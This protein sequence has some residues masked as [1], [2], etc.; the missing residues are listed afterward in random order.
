ML[1]RF[2]TAY[3]AWQERSRER[4]LH[5]HAGDTGAY[6]CDKHL[7]DKWTISADDAA[8]IGFE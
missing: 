7:C 5:F 8:R 4:A 2:I 1:R 6:A 3:S